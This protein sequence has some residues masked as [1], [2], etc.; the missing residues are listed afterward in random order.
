MH[1]SS[2][3]TVFSIPTTAAAAA[4]AIPLS[5]VSQTLART[6]SHLAA[7]KTPAS[8]PKSTACTTA[9]S[10]NVTNH[11]LEGSSVLRALPEVQWHVHL[12]ATAPHQPL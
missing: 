7:Q 6:S 4:A 1:S 11:P 2:F 12:T 9:A 10:P 3:P 8:S 5:N